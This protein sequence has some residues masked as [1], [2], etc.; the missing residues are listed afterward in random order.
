MRASET[1]EKEV[2]GVTG[3]TQQEEG[4]HHVGADLPITMDDDND[5]SGNDADDKRDRDAHAHDGRAWQAI[6]N[7]RHDQVPVGRS[8]PKLPDNRPVTENHD[9]ERYDADGGEVDPRPVVE[10]VVE[11]TRRQRTANDDVTR[12]VDVW[13]EH[14]ED[15]G[16]LDESESEKRRATHAGVA[17]CAHAKLP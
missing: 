1:V 3:V 8:T 5:T 7:S 4:L 17:R 2:D 15:V 11:V 14:D 9:A 13:G 6:D 16:V 12:I 10:H